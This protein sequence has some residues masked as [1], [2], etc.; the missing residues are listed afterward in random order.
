MLHV[1]SYE[2][3]QKLELN[4]SI[5]SSSKQRGGPEK[6]RG[7]V[8]ALEDQAA[9]KEEGSAHLSQ[10]SPVWG[11]VLKINIDHGPSLK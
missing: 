11:W 3:T 6:G 2:E 7:E 10:C 9:D 8:W 4:T 5:C 1:D